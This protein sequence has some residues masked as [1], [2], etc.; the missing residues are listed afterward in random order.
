[1]DTPFVTT[2]PLPISTDPLPAFGYQ[3]RRKNPGCLKLSIFD[4][5]VQTSDG[6]R[7]FTPA[8][9]GWSR[10]LSTGRVRRE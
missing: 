7:V 3:P 2:S 10:Y 9:A 5:T 8:G 1:M 4:Y 6:E